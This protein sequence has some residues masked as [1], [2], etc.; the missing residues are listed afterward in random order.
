M[1]GTNNRF[2][3][4]DKV[5][6]ISDLNVVHIGQKSDSITLYSHADWVS[7][8]KSIYVRYDMYE[9]LKNRVYKT[10]RRKTMYGEEYFNFWWKPMYDQ[11]VSLGELELSSYQLLTPGGT[12][13]DRLLF[14]AM[15]TTDSDGKQTIS[16]N[17]QPWGIDL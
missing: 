12:T 14:S 17:T 13:W 15:S 1:P 8:K 7:Y 9:P 2:L 3:Q 10:F 5:E 6:H 4:F 11:A 16:L